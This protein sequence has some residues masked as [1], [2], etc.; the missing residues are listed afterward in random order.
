MKGKIIIIYLIMYLSSCLSSNTMDFPD[1]IKTEKTT[2]HIRI[3]GTKLFVIVPDD[4][5]YIKELARYQKN[6]KLYIQVMEFNNMSFT[7]NKKFLAKDSILKTG[8][9]I[10]V[11]KTFKFNNFDAIYAEGPSKFPGETKFGCFFGD[12]SSYII[13][14]CVCKDTDKEGKKQLLKIL[15]TSYYDKNFKLD[16]LELANF[17][18]D[19]TILGYDYKQTV[20]NSF[21]Y[22]PKENNISDSSFSR[23]IGISAMTET[24]FDAAK[25]FL[26]YSY[27]RSLLNN[28]EPINIIRS[29]KYINNYQSYFIEGDV[30]YDDISSFLYQAIL[31]GKKSS[32]YFYGVTSNIEEKEKLIQTVESIEIK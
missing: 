9:K 12:D 31:I 14:G 8:A 6:D 16:P 10:D 26:D 27:E 32:V 23:F 24:T 15:K 3:L 19:Q 20:S 13:V 5:V 30:L 1:E 22:A 2:K 17:N 4:F 25:E 29:E 28:V 18:F 7:E 21:I 11:Y